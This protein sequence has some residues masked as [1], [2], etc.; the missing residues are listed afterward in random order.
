MTTPILVVCI[1]WIPVV[2][3][4]CVVSAVVSSYAVAVHNNHTVAVIPYISDCANYAPES[5][6]FSQL[7]NITAAIAAFM[8]LVRYKLLN[9]YLSSDCSRAS[10]SSSTTKHLTRAN[11]AALVFG[12]LSAFG[13]S[14][15]GNFQDRTVTILHSIGAILAFAICIVYCC[16]QT[17]ISAFTARRP[18]QADS[19][20]L[21]CDDQ[22][23]SRS[24]CLP[25]SAARP[26]VGKTL[27]AI[28]LC[29]CVGLVVSFVLYEVFLTSSMSKFDGENTLFWKSSHQG[30]TDHVISCASQWT[31]FSCIV[32]FMLSHAVEFRRIRQM[33]LVDIQLD[34][35]CSSFYHGAEREVQ[36]TTV[37]RGYATTVAVSAD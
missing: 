7:M 31:L 18:A 3:S 4:I 33:S 21:T 2:G 9:A 26:L 27:V 13:I 28:R 10:N 12:L 30:W 1:P 20:T 36:S 6:I 8:Y 32:L 14:L 17:V 22:P 19:E 35:Q 15:V 29:V 37:A 5:C 11:T 16:L 24:S 25:R 34:Y 23:P